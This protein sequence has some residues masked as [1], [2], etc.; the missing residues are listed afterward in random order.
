MCDK[1]DKRFMALATS[2]ATWSKDPSTQVGCI[3]VGQDR[4]ILATGYNGFAKGV[5]DSP[6]RLN[7]RPVKY[8]LVLHA[9]VNAVLNSTASLHG[10]TAYVT[11]SPCAQCTSVLAQ[12]GIVRIVTQPTPAGLLERF[13]ESFVLADSIRDETGI[14]YQILEGCTCS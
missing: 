9:E 2:V 1:W 8:Q 11:H 4:K 10:S 6:E 12:S 14:Q 13:K 3:I 5:V 7:D